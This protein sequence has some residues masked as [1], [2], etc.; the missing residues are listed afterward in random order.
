MDGMIPTSKREIKFRALVEDKQTKE[1]HWEFY[2]TFSQ[3]A[4]PELYHIIVA[5]LQYTGLK[6]K[7]GKEI[8]E[9]DIVKTDNDYTQVIEWSELFGERGMDGLSEGF[10]IGFDI[11]TKTRDIEITG[12]I[13][14]DKRLLE[15]GNSP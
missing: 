3:S 12:N 8:Y 2:T 1:R 4:W 13:F 5:D 10:N 6:D 7:N 15:K 11:E 9:G 14:E